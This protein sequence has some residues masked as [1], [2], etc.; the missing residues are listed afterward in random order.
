MIS[1]AILLSSGLPCCTEGPSRFMPKAAKAALISP[2][3]TLSLAAAR[4]IEAGGNICDYC[5]LWPWLW[6]WPLA[7]SVWPDRFFLV[8]DLCL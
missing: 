6:L 8:T 5:W 4:C 3:F 7:L 2:V 1:W